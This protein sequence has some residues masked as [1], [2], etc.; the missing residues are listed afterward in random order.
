MH[1]FGSW[2]VK[3]REERGLSQ[4]ALAKKMNFSQAAISRLEADLVSPSPDLLKAVAK[5]LA[6]PVEQ[7]LRAAGLLAPISDRDALKENLDLELSDLTTEEKRIILSIAKGM[8]EAKKNNR[9]PRG[10]EARNTA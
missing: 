2:L 7:V 6:I 3:Q 4:N 5:A 1:S 9:K 10:V 8:K